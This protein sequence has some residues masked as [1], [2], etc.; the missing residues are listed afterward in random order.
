M[1]RRNKPPASQSLLFE[2]ILAKLDTFAGKLTF[3]VAIVGAGF[4][5]GGYYTETQM[6]K[7]QNRIERNLMN[8]WSTKEQIFK[9]EIDALKS[10][11]D[12]LKNERLELKAIIYELKRQNSNE[13]RK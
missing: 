6:T 13:A 8:E 11:I 10:E 5:V 4:K 9:S 1:S 7:E 12:M 3:I 2:R